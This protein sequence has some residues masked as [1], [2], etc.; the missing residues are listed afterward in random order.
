MV[1]AIRIHSTGGPEVLHWDEVDLGAPGAGQALVR[2]AAI[3]LNFIDTYH[4]SGLYPLPLPAILGTEASGVVEA[5][6]K[7]VRSVRVGDR[8]A[9]AG[10]AGAYCEARL[11]AADR[12]VP[13]PDGMDDRT[14]AAVTLKGMTAHM[15]LRRTHRAKR[16]E[17]ILLHA[18]AGGLGLLVAQWAKHLGVTVIGAV[19]SEAKAAAARGHGCDHVVV[20]SRDD[21]VAR[22]KEITGGRGV[23]VVY[24][25]VG[26]DTWEASLSS[27]R[28]L[29]MAV[30]CGNASG[31]VPPVAP[32][33]LAAKGSLFMTR[34]VLMTY[35]AA[36]KDLLAAAREL[37]EVVRSG[38][39]KVEVNQSYPLREAAQAHRDLEGRRTTGSTVLLP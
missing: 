31:P 16:G 2:H 34:P 3:G 26:R 22:V 8:V 5:V 33:M 13:L 29:G 27:L 28:P 6:G 25:S 12:L 35:V 36:R 17:T 30:F 23:D 20:T 18:A 39:V 15:L 14:A 7:G 10:P 32:S 37:F 24:D 21:L 9:Y 1:K 38:A 19:G 11:I 4:R